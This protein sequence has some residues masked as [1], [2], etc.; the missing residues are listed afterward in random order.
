MCQ[1]TQTF[2]DGCESAVGIDFGT[3]W[4]GIHKCETSTDG[5]SCSH[6]PEQMSF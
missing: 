4:Q 2:E 3:R 6:D 1:A 5:E